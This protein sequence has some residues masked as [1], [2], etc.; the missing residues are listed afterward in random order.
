MEQQDKTMAYDME[1]YWNDSHT[2]AGHS[3]YLESLY[4]SYIENPASVSIEW[5]NFFDDL[6][7]ING[8]NKDISHQSVINSFKNYRRVASAASNKSESNDKQVKVIQLIQAYR[9]RGHQVASI[10]PLG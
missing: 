10:D 3:S 7:N 8:S 4:E 9:N 2:S 1:K 5:R 6:P